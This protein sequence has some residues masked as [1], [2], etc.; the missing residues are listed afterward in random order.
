MFSWKLGTSSSM[1]IWWRGIRK[2]I[3]AIRK[4]K[5]EL[6][7]YVFEGQGNI[8]GRLEEEMEKIYELFF[9]KIISISSKGDGGRRRVDE[10]ILDLATRK[11][12]EE[13]GNSSR[14]YE[15]KCLKILI[16]YRNYR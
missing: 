1:E 6:R 7:N 13:V 5:S 12:G 8:G 2:V 16:L 3:K 14:R 9:R 11:V 10:G 4:R 15:R